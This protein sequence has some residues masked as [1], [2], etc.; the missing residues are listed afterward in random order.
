MLVLD[1]CEISDN[2]ANS[3]AA[4][5]IARQGSR[6]GTDAVPTIVVVNNT[7]IARNRVIDLGAAFNMAS[8]QQVVFQNTIFVNN[9]GVTGLLGMLPS[10][11]ICWACYSAALNLSADAPLCTG[12]N[13]GAG[14]CQGDGTA[15]LGLSIYSSRFEVCHTT[16]A[17]W[18]TAVCHGDVAS[19]LATH[20]ACKWAEAT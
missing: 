15:S 16:R 9:S 6:G 7:V 11:G 19:S 10:P 18:L 3:G 14:Y 1:Q 13:G 8:C 4:I 20:A 17:S 2:F 5:E 12:Q